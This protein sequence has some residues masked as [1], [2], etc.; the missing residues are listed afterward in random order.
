MHET[1]F[2]MFDSNE[3]YQF[4]VIKEYFNGF[5]LFDGTHID[6]ITVTSGLNQIN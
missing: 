5:E 2:D 3:L 4:R 1:P 6:L